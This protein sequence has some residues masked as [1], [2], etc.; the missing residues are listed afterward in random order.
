MK[1]LLLIIAFIAISI[2]VFC[3]ETESVYAYQSGTWSDTKRNW[4]WSSIEKSNLTI[5]FDKSVISI[6]NKLGSRFETLYVTEEGDDFISWK[7]L[8]EESIFCTV[9]MKT[10]DN[11]YVLIIVYENLCFRYFY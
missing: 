2:S 11:G 7:A 5:T 3:Q 8:D 10:L 4:V 9:T 6:D 1:K